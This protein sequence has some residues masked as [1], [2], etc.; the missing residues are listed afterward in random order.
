MFPIAHDN[1][2][3]SDQS[4]RPQIQC[5]RAFNASSLAHQITN[6][7]V[8]SFYAARSSRQ[9]QFWIFPIGSE[10]VDPPEK[11][12][13]DHA[14][15]AQSC[16]FANEM[17]QFFEHGLQPG[18][19]GQLQSFADLLVKRFAQR[20]ACQVAIAAAPAVLQAADEMKMAELHDPALAFAEPDN[21]G[22]LVGDRSPDASV[23]GGGDR[24]E[25][26]RP[27]L[28]I[29]SSRPEHRIDE[30]GSTLMARLDRHQIQDPVFSSKAKVK[31]VQDQN[32]R[33]SW[34]AQTP[35]S[36]YELSQCSTKTPT[37]PLMGKA[38]TWSE[39]FQ[40]A[41]VQQ[42]CLQNSRTRSPRL[43]ASSFVADSPCTLA[44]TALTTSR[45]E[46]MNSCSATWGFRVPRMHARELHT[47]WESKYRKTR[48]NSV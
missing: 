27:A 44:V 10:M 39:S 12:P 5:L 35:R 26:L 17:P 30:D 21:S 16:R 2:T 23:N 46:V 20:S 40:C 32:Q 47:G 42:D 31:S 25:C 36:R 14:H 6:S 9:I 48:G 13:N 37:Q 19:I 4:P 38:V 8:H 34:Q 3:C 43:A 29:L 1:W 7:S 15:D 18:T 22:N 33:S 28:H 41:S 11:L 45:T 24:R